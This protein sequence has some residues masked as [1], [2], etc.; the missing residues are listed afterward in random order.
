MKGHLVERSPG[1]WAVV[2]D[3]ADPE[4]G[5]RKRKWHSFKGT[6]RQAQDE[7]ARL[8]TEMR[9][10]SYIEPGKMKVAE[11]LERWLEHTKSQV[12][13]RTHERYVEVVRKN[14]VPLIGSIALTKLRPV[15]ISDAYVKALASGR[16]DGKGGLSPRTVHHLHRILKQ[17][18]SQAV[19]WSLLVRNPAD[20]IDPPKVE[21]AKM[22]ALDAS[23]IVRLLDAFRP[24]RMFVPVLLGVLCGLRRGEIAALRWGSVDL[25]RAQMSVSESME[26]TRAG[27]RRK[28]TKNGRSRTVALPGYVVDELRQHRVRQ[29]EELL[30]IGIRITEDTTVVAQADG[31]PLQPNSL[32]H[33]WVRIL[34]GTTLPR[35]RLHDLR[36][37]HATQ[38]L[39][40][41]VHPKVAQERLGHSTVGVTLDLYSHT[42][43]GMDVDAAAKVDAALRAAI[44]KR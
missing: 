24:T 36:H 3:V 17:A 29:A 32:T 39:I 41:G 15:Q 31:K 14:L 10:G 28:D 25:Q 13:P 44:D 7:A 4:K 40:N 22:K 5:K 34:A 43:P 26:Q 6:K 12:A 8:I 19:R 42:I 33:E 16:R 2:L 11:F 23:E 21:R 20:A 38:L 18:L 30:R 37:T 9:S 1:H 27:I 35:V